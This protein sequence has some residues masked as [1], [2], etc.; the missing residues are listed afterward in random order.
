MSSVRPCPGSGWIAASLS[1]AILAISTSAC[2]RIGA[3]TKP[4]EGRQMATPLA[5]HGPCL[6]TFGNRVEAASV[7]ADGQRLVYLSS[8]RP[9]ALPED[10]GWSRD[11]RAVHVLDMTADGGVT[12]RLLVLPWPAAD[13]DRIPVYPTADPDDLSPPEAALLTSRLTSLVMSQTGG[14]VVLG[15]NREGVKGGLA[16]LYTGLVPEGDDQLSP[17]SGLTLVRMNDYAG[18]EGVRSVVL[19]PDG[20]KMA[21]LVGLNG[22]VRVYD[23]GAD[24]L[25][26]YDQG[27]DGKVQVSHDLPPAATSLG[28]D[29]TPALA[30]NG[31]MRMQWSP[32][33]NRLAITRYESVGIAG[34]WVVEVATGDA[35][36][37]RT[38]SNTTVPHVAWSGDGR[39]VFALTTRL[40]QGNVLG[41]SEVRRINAVEDGKDIGDR[42]SLKQVAG[43][44]TSPADFTAY[45]DDQNFLFTWEEQLWL[46]Q[47]PASGSGPATYGPVT[48]NPPAMRVM[49]GNVSVAPASDRAVFLVQDAQGTHVGVRLAASQET[50]E[51]DVGAAPVEGEAAP[52]AGEETEGGEAEGQDADDAEAAATPEG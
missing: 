28:Q 41:D 32:D 34:L 9:A 5:N 4:D 6:P 48:L 17:G 33:A 23:F 44:K 52:A 40:F 10:S 22:E 15:V 19:S 3:S 25:Y 31:I 49:S 8:A 50:C 39:S 47:V 26:V 2:D 11:D 12:T 45:G 16:K 7:S 18:T 30:H 43:Y 24:K 13:E 42:W 14:R 38:F 29:R 51:G 21:A 36:L 27:E 1:L 46:L 35:T 37:V 20:S